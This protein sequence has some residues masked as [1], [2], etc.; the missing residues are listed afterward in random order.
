MNILIVDD[1]HMVCRGIQTIIERTDWGWTVAGSASNGREALELMEQQ[2]IDVVITDIKMPEM[3]GLQMMECIHNRGYRCEMIVLSSYADFEFARKAVK[4]RA[5]NY[6]LKPVDPD[7]L[8]KD[9][10]KAEQAG[11]ERSPR[12]L[13]QEQLHDSAQDPASASAGKKSRRIIEQIKA[14]IHERYHQDLQIRAI[15][16]E[17]NMN[18]S[19]LSDLFKQY[20]N[21]TFT[22]FLIEYRIQKARELLLTDTGMKMYEVAEAVGYRNPKHFSQIF[23]KHVGEFP[24]DFRDRVH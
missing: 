13:S 5:M 21:L 4:Y 7:E 18:S 22:E 3:D 11:Q 14:I 1:E 20:T 15:A 2:E 19:Y 17:L 10:Q 23:K 8:I 9:L 16:D 24:I 6:L 12:P